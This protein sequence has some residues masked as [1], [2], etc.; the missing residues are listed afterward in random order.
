MGI[1]KHVESPFAGESF[2][3]VVQIDI[4]SYDDR[5]KPYGNP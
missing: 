1:F 4:W 3:V 5:P 2:W